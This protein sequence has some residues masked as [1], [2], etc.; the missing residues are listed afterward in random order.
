MVGVTA[1]VG[2]DMESMNELSALAGDACF[3][4]RVSGPPDTHI[5][6]IS[7]EIPRTKVILLLV[8]M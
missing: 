1:G 4:R 6:R 5:H 7:S 8:T 3:S 2:L